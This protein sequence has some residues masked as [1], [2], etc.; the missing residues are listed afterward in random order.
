MEYKQ[1]GYVYQ[2]ALMPDG[3]CYMIFEALNWVLAGY[4]GTY[5]ITDDNIL[6]VTLDFHSKG[7]YSVSFA[8][9][10]QAQTLTQVS[11][12]GFPSFQEAGVVYDY[13]PTEDSPEAIAERAVNL[14]KNGGFS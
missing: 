6:I 13:Q 10:T 3:T 2:Y 8:V 7:A 5:T 14:E 9:D 11:A 4:S 12:Q 1:S